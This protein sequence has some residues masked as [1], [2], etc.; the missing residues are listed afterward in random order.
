M[1]FS[2]IVALFIT[3]KVSLEAA[4][5]MLANNLGYTNRAM[6]YALLNAARETP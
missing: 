1:A 4:A 2:T 5:D 3:G 6:A